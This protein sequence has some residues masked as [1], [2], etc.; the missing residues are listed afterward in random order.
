MRYDKTE[1]WNRSLRERRPG[2]GL[3]AS[4]LAPSGRPPDIGEMDG[5]ISKLEGAFDWIK[6]TVSLIA[7]VLIGGIAFIGV[8]IT[9]VDGRISALS[10]QVNGLPEKV[11]ANLRD[12]TSTL[13]QAI[14]A[15]KQTPPQVILMPAP[16]IPAT[17]PQTS[18]PAK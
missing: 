6:V 9:R 15:S 10:D 13:S 1:E 18:S 3:N 11:N 7:A 4:T 8:Q 12:L 16:Q 5:R 17:A 14:S 2:N